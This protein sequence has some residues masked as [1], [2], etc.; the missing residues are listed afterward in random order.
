MNSSGALSQDQACLDQCTTSVAW[1]VEQIPG[2][3]SG[4]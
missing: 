3:Y 2:R 1:S 4:N